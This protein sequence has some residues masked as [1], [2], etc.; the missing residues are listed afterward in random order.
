MRGITHVY[1]YR[2]GRCH[3]DHCC[4][5][6]GPA[7][8]ANPPASVSAASTSAVSSANSLAIPGSSPKDSPSPAPSPE[9]SR[10]KRA[11]AS[12]QRRALDSV[13]S[14]RSASSP[15]AALTI[16]ACR[17]PIC[18]GTV[19]VRAPGT[20]ATGRTTAGPPRL[21]CAIS[22]TAAATSLRPD[23]RQARSAKKRRPPSPSRTNTWER[24]SATTWQYRPDSPTG[25]PPGRPPGC[26]MN[27]PRSASADR[28]Q[29]MAS[30]ALPM[31]ITG[32]CARRSARAASRRDPC[33]GRTPRS[34][35]PA[36]RAATSAL[37]RCRADCPDRRR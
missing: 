21:S 12:P 4:Y 15:G 33:G 6:L 20:E 31:I 19:T 36:P 17:A 3:R 11:S 24:W 28:S 18:V 26:P 5:R 16:I 13:R 25:R 1:R 2:D 29:S 35:R 9:A 23:R 34:S 32:P 8:V 7:E 37:R 30:S 22:L 14:A 27:P 10:C